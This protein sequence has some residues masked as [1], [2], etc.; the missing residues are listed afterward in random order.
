MCWQILVN[1]YK[2]TSTDLRL[3]CIHVAF[4][5]Q[6]TY[7]V[8]RIRALFGSLHK[9]E[10]LTELFVSASRSPI[11]YTC[12]KNKIVRAIMTSTFDFMICNSFSV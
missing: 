1:S 6:L 10:K 4:G 9:E 12:L 11:P 2:F 8:A 5:P 3:F 7:V